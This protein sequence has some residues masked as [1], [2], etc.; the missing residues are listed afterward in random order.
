MPGRRASSS[1]RSWIGPPYTLG[2][3]LRAQL[4]L[5][6]GDGVLGGDRRPIL[7]VVD[8]AA[9]M[10]GQLVPHQ[11]LDARRHAE[12]LDERRLQLGFARLHLLDAELLSRSERD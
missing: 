6:P 12:D 10:V 11:A 1:I 3:R 8:P 2:L 7:V 9:Q 4:G 5:Q